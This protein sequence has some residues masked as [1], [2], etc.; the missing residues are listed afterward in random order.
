MSRKFKKTE[1]QIFFRYLYQ[2]G[3]VPL[4]GTTSEQHM[5]EDL[6][7]FD[8]ELPAEDTKALGL[9]LYHR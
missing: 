6:S 5:I 9:L 4:T 3:V 1:V 2:S 7:I 8:F